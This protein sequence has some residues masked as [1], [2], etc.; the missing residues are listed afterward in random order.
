MKESRFWLLLSKK[1]AGEAS[2][3]ELRELSYWMGDRDFPYRDDHHLVH[4]LWQQPFNEEDIPDREVA[5][6]ALSGKLRLK[7][8]VTSRFSGKTFH[9]GL[10]RRKWIAA[11]SMLLLAGTGIIYTR[12]T[13]PEVPV[14]SAGQND[15]FVRNGSRTKVIL[16]DGSILWLN[17]GSRLYYNKSFGQDDRVVY[18]TGEGYF[19]V[20][21]NPNLPFIVHAG[22]IT[23]RVLG[24]CF[25]VKAYSNEKKIETVLVKGKIEITIGNDSGR[26]IL[27]NPL[28][29]ITLSEPAPAKKNA[30]KPEVES[31]LYSVTRIVPQG[32]DSIVAETAWLNN[33]FVF[34]GMSFQELSR[35]IERWYGVT[36]LFEDPSL[37]TKKFTGVFDQL[38][39]EQ[40]L[41]AL[42]FSSHYGFNYMVRNGEVTIRK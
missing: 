32:R 27:L 16:P 19:E 4:E 15:V 37:K 25:N 12:P 9:M 24:T 13:R 7:D 41:D 42:R 28:E 34:S 21:P 6:S 14:Q 39:L 23:I 33:K 29:R 3:E 35:E 30:C 40:A 17:G 38:S 22:A 20:T 11:A 31:P 2:E 36:L 5:W 1:M 10:S 8:R 18:L 26:K